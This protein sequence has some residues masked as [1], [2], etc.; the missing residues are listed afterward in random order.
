MGRL[1]KIALLNRCRS[2][3]DKEKLANFQKAFQRAGIEVEH[4]RKSE[5]IDPYEPDCVIIFSLQDPK[6]TKFPTYGLIEEPLNNILASNRLIRNLLTYDGYL[7][8]FSETEN[9]INDLIFSSRKIGSSVARFGSTSCLEEPHVPLLDNPKIVYCSSSDDLQRFSEITYLLG[10]SNASVLLTK[11]EDNYDEISF[12][13]KKHGVGLCLNNGTGIDKLISP[14]FFRIIAQGALAIANH[15]DYLEEIFGD[16]VLYISSEDSV[17]RVYRKIL[18]HLEWV[19]ENPLEAQRKAV[20]AQEIFYKKFALEVLIP[21][22]LHLHKTIL[23][24]KGYLPL[25]PKNKNS[26]PS[27][28]YIMRTGGRH[29]EFLERALNSL[30]SQGYPNIQ[31][32]FVVYKPFEYMDDVIHKFS[33]HLKFKVVEALNSLRSTAI[34]EGL[35]AVDTDLFGLFDDDDELH[36]N[37]VQSLVKTLEYHNNLNDLRGPIKLAYSSAYIVSEGWIVEEKDEWVDH[38][39]D[40]N[41]Q[42][43]RVIEHYRIFN[44]EDISNHLWYTSSNSWLA[45]KE[46]IDIELI[47]DPKTDT[48]EDLYFEL[49]MAQ[50]TYFAFSGEVTCVHHHHSL[51]NSTFLDSNRHIFDSIKHGLRVH[52]RTFPKAQNYYPNFLTYQ[53]QR[54]SAIVP[55]SL[56]PLPSYGYEASNINKNIIED[57]REEKTLQGPLEGKTQRSDFPLFYTHQRSF[58]STFPHVW[59]ASRGKKYYLFLRFKEVVELQGWGSA[60]RAYQN[61][62]RKAEYRPSN[63]YSVFPTALNLVWK[64]LKL[65]NK[66]RKNVFYRVKYIL[67]LKGLKGLRKNFFYFIKTRKTTD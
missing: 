5:E 32:I 34:I 27:V 47:Q 52:L 44:P 3:S 54:S 8:L 66:K 51:G 7:T 67:K 23:S 42:E 36:S 43:H 55:F 46:L 24:E 13:Y 62:A 61:Y 15:N 26:L 40:K 56:G 25:S 21:N 12:L 2:F 9:I 29:R 1:A 41:W 57:S 18:N 35:K 50:K 39:L 53:K 16:T 38:T 6:L 31:V 28:S 60:I 58:I 22:L 33:P 14:D 17:D 59:A 11:D 63:S 48:C 10:S 65:P 49:Q 45:K 30:V 4:F 37:H 20:I 19:K 64:I